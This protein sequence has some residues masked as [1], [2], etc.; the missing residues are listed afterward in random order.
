M[1]HEN[2]EA[3]HQQKIWA[4]LEKNNGLLFFVS[5]IVG[6]WKEGSGVNRKC[7]HCLPP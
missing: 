7:H 1:R 4:I 3:K 6:L 5:A 2:E